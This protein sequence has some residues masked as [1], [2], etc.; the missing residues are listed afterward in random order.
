MSSS[1]HSVLSDARSGA[2][3]SMV[4]ESAAAS[5]WMT[6]TNRACVS[7]SMP[8]K[9]RSVSTAARMFASAPAGVRERLQDGLHA[10]PDLHRLR[11]VV[12]AEHEAR[13]GALPHVAVRLVLGIRRGACPRRTGARC[14][15]RSCAPAAVTK[16]ATVGGVA[17][18]RRACTV[19]SACA[20]RLR[21]RIANTDRPSPTRP[22]SAT[23]ELSPAACPRASSP[24][25]CRG[26]CAPRGCRRA[27]P[28]SPR[29]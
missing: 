17:F 27:P 13:D 16:L 1:S 19:S 3:R 18:A 14:T 15:R 26:G 22:A 25:G 11:D 20:T 21:S 7:S 6:R 28:A 24:G 9:A 4:S 12:D 8:G 23:A 10:A 2:V 5:S 29:R